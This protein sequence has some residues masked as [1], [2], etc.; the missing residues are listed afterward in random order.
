MFERWGIMFALALSL[1][2][3]SVDSIAGPIQEELLRVAPTYLGTREYGDNR[4]R[5][6]EAILRNVGLDPGNPWCMALVY[7]IHK[8]AYANLKQQNP[9]PKTGLAAGY[10]LYAGKRKLTFKIIPANQ[11]L[12]GAQV[13]PADV[14]IW[15]RGSFRSDGTFKGHAAV[16]MYQIDKKTFKSID[17]NTGADEGGDQ[18]EGDGCFLKTR[19]LGV[20]KFLVMGFVRIR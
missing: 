10:W 9:V 8:D 4:G 3:S 13:S 12:L 5:E 15:K 1:L 16:V 14:A 6:V 19:K 11:V 7:T 18:G 2:V 17:G 20:Q